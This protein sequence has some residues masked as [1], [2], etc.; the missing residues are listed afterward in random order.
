MRINLLVF[1]IF[2]FTFASAFSKEEVDINKLVDKKYEE[3]RD[4]QI[5]KRTWKIKDKRNIKELILDAAI[6]FRSKNKEP[7]EVWTMMFYPL[8]L[9]NIDTTNLSQYKFAVC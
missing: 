2:N 4:E 9:L 3:F 7:D 8:K 5:V 6:K 1:L